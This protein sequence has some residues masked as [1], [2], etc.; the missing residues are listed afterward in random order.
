MAIMDLSGRVQLLE[1]CYAIAGFVRPSVH[2]HLGRS[3]IDL[4]VRLGR[5]R[6]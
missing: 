5:C 4:D 1:V 6:C 3:I 2:A